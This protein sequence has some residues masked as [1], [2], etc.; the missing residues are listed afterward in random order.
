[1]T[2]RR[3]SRSP[4]H[5]LYGYAR[6]A[7]IFLPHGPQCRLRQMPTLQPRFHPP[8]NHHPLHHWDN[9]FVLRSA[10]NDWLLLRLP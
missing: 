2:S 10:G 4:H 1:M 8:V 5:R 7:T 6:P 3:R 9:L